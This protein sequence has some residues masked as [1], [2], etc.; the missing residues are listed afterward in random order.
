MRKARDLNYKKIYK[1]YIDE[2]RVALKSDNYG[3]YI[4]ISG[5]ESGISF[6]ASKKLNTWLTRANKYLKKKS[7]SKNRA[8]KMIFSS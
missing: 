2:V 4:Q 7:L 1:N 8:N 3:N 6:E 5:I